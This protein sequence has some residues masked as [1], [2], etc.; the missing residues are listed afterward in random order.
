M[1]FENVNQIKSFS[2]LGCECDNKGRWNKERDGEGDWCW[3]KESPCIMNGEEVEWTMA[4]C[5]GSGIQRV[6]C[7]V[8]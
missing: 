1:I 6:D 5:K 8:Q 4:R 7:F 2:D 3:L